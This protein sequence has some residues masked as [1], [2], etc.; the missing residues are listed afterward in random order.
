MP[1]K[2]KD[3]N[4]TAVYVDNFTQGLCRNAGFEKGFFM[5]FNLD[6]VNGTP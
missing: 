4:F 3:R 1:A 6:K 5:V 2:N